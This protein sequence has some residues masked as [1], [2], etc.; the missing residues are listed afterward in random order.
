MKTINLII[1]CLTLV[2][3]LVSIFFNN[4][5]MKELEKEIERLKKK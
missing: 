3:L 1:D 4:K 5:K 2:F